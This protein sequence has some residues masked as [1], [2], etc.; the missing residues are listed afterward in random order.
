MSR[1][2]WVRSAHLSTILHSKAFLRTVNL[3]AHFYIFHKLT[4]HAPTLKYKLISSQRVQ[5]LMTIDNI[6]S[7]TKT[8]I[9]HYPLLS[10]T[11]PT[12]DPDEPQDLL[13]FWAVCLVGSCQKPYRNGCRLGTSKARSSCSLLAISSKHPVC[14]ELPFIKLC[15]LSPINLCP[16]KLRFTFLELIPKI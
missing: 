8:T 12:S 15:C 14:P 7:V 1:D 13:L 5:S 3:M 9:S 11:E 6:L 16:S 4:Y 2:S 10:T